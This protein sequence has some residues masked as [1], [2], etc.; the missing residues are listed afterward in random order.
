[1]SAP[2]QIGLDDVTLDD[3][4]W[5]L[6]AYLFTPLVPLFILMLDDVRQRPFV[7]AHLGQALAL[8]VV[9]VALLVLAPFTLCLTSFLFVLLYA[10][11]VYWGVQAYN[12]QIVR[13]PYVSDY[14]QQQGW[15]S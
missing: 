2:S 9:A 11:I 3:R 13:I 15:F 1:M 6:L 7:K 10:A 5:A 8:G 14:V 4:R 12:G